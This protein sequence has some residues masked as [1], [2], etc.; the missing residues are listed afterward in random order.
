MISRGEGLL[1]LNLG[2][3]LDPISHVKS[4]DPIFKI[5]IIDVRNGV[6]IKQI[7]DHTTLLSNPIVLRLGTYIVEATNGEDVDAAFESPYYKGR[8]TVE[9][10]EGQT[11]TADI[12]CTL[13][14]VK[15]AVAFSESVLENFTVYDVTVNN[16]L[17]SLFFDK[18]NNLRK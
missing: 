13:A 3:D 9:L 7:D 16:T 11:A 2:Y 6:T 15:V 4:E 1:S 18:E 8:D 12:T 10:V 17:D 5:N 14:N